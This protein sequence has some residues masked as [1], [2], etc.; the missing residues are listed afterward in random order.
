MKTYKEARREIQDKN[1]R[2]PVKAVATWD[3]TGDF[4]LLGDDISMVEYAV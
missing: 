1:L 3:I 2:R 4:A